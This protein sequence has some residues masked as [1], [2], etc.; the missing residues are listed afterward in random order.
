MPGSLRTTDQP[1]DTRNSGTRKQAT[2]EKQS[3]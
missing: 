1:N 2:F 3:S